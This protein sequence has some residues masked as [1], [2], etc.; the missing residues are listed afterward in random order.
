MLH[1]YRN[2]VVEWV[3]AFSEI[4]AALVH[5]AE[6]FRTGYDSAFIRDEADLSFAQEPDDKMLHIRE[7]STWPD[8][9]HGAE[10]RECREWAA[11]HG[12]GFLCTTEW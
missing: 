3:V 6:L 4:D 12:R 7:Y 9:D 10:R 5:G 11:A 2:G 8:G 1:V